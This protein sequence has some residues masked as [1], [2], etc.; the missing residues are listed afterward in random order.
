MTPTPGW[1]SATGSGLTAHSVRLITLTSDF[2]E[3]SPYIA[4]M[5]A[6]LLAHCP[7]A[8]LIDVSH[9]VPAF[10]TLAGAFVLWAGTR[11]FQA[12][13]VHLAVVDP[14]VGSARRPVAFRASGSWFVGPDN[15][16]F[17]LVL[18]EC[19]DGE[20]SEALEL[21]RPEHASPTFEGRDV[22][23]PAAG[24]LAA[25]SPAARLGRRLTTPLLVLPLEEPRVLW[26]DGFGNLVTNLKPPLKGL[27]IRDREIHGLV[28]TFSDAPSG[29]PFLY[30]GSTGYVEIGVWK[31]RADR[32][33]DASAG[34]TIEP[35]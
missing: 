32:V 31:A 27:R 2:G 14:G 1:S 22:F 5:K 19:G 9:S 23:A 24:A 15:G 20:P 26:V 34:T 28:R 13:G 12:G 21:T 10:D 35:L 4:A 16:V 25:G 7:S 30:V 11:H 8:T 17:S 3:G 6:Q 18:A 29:A 33:L